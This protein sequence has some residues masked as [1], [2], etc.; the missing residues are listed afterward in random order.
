MTGSQGVVVVV[1]VAVVDGEEDVVVVVVEKE[2]DP[3]KASRGG[4]KPWT[5]AAPI[6]AKSNR[7]CH[8]WRLGAC[9]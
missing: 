7:K 4:T 5:K 3:S 8:F 9:K 1:V 6:S 2:E